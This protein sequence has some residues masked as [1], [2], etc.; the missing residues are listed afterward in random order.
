MQCATETVR[1]AAV[2][3]RVRVPSRFPFLAIACVAAAVDTGAQTNAWRQCLAD[4][5]PAAI[6]AC[7]SIIFWILATTARS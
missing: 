1:L 6:E 4:T 7:T 2:V 5:S 3:C